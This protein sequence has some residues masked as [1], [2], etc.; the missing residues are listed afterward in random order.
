[1]YQSECLGR[2]T[3]STKVDEEMLEF[4]QDQSDYYGVPTAEFLRRLLRVYQESQRGNIVCPS[5]SEEINLRL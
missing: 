5:C 4:I 1:M 2:N 3:V